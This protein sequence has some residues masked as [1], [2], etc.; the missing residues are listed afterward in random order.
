[1]AAAG[2]DPSTLSTRGAKL[3]DLHRGGWDP[4][5]READQDRDKVVAEIIYPSVGMVLCNHPDFA[6]KRACFD[7]Y[8]RWLKDLCGGLPNRLYGMPQIVMETPEFGIEEVRKPTDMGFKGVM[9]HGF[10][11]SALGGPRTR[12]G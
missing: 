7:A 1:M 11:D 5:A 3:N 12:Q 2:K 10:L 8:N 4:K 6:Y 9:M